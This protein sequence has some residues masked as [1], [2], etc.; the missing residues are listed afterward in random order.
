MIGSILIANRGEI[1]VRVVRACK[2]LGIR[3]VVAYSTADKDT[4]A[5]QMA[6]Q[7]VC[8]GGPETKE[9]YLKSKNIIMA[10]CLT[11]CD[12]VHPGVGFL[13]ENAGFAKA[14]E[15]AGLIFIGIAGIVSGN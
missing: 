10:A 12:A 14:V 9:S 7:A 5:V 13:S 3:S 6:D 11:R 15:D 4:L 8:I 1:A 2:D